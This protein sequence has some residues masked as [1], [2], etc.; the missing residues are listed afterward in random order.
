MFIHWERCEGSEILNERWQLP[1]MHRAVSKH[2]FWGGIHKRTS[3]FPSLNW[4]GINTSSVR[5]LAFLRNNLCPA[6]RGTLYKLCHKPQLTRGSLFEN[7]NMAY[8]FIHPVLTARL[9]GLVEIIFILISQ[10]LNAQGSLH[11]G[12]FCKISQTRYQTE[13]NHYIQNCSKRTMNF[14]TTHSIN[15]RVS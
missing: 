6:C 11:R 12:C 10:T 7:W 3:V 13:N 2:A 14:H 1:D 8:R 9:C 15:K 4:H 5:Y